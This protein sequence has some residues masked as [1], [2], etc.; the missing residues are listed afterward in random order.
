MHPPPVPSGAQAL[1]PVPR[2]SDAE[3][4]QERRPGPGTLPQRQAYLLFHVHLI[5]EAKLI[6]DLLQISHDAVCSRTIYVGDEVHS[7]S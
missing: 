5:R 3:N 4:R 7:D 6:N 1:D 2:I